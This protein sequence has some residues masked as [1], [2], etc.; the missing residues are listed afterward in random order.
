VTALDPAE[1]MMEQ[2]RALDAEAG[3]QVRY[4]VGKAEE[5]GLAEKSFDVVTAGQCWHWFDRPKAAAEVLRLLAPGG[6]LVICHYDWIPLPGNVVYATERLIE[7]HNP[8]WK[9][10]GGLGMHPLWTVDTGAAG[11]VAIETFS[12]D[13]PAIYS[14]E[15]WRG[16]VRA[17]AGISA[18]LAPAAVE[19]F[20]REHAALLAREFPEDPLAVHHRC[21]ALVARKPGG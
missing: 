16:R 4:V 1:K 9:A 6:R 17:S 20:D 19:A 5:T 8:A 21:W 2:A 13:L 12:F 14:H 3:V 18:S 11:F 7:K 15:D 10:G